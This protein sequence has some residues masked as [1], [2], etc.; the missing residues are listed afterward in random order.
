[1]GQFSPQLAAG[2][3]VALNVA[4]P[5]QQDILEKLKASKRTLQQALESV[6]LSLKLQDL[7]SQKEK[8]QSNN[9]NAKMDR[10]FEDR[11]KAMKAQLEELKSKLASVGQTD[12]FKA[13]TE[14][15]GNAVKIIEEVNK[16]LE[17]YHRTLTPGQKAEIDALA[18]QEKQTEVE[19]AYQT[20]LDSTTRSIQERIAAAQALTKA[21]G[22]GY[23]AVKAASVGAQLAST[24]GREFNDPAR[25]IDQARL[26]SQLEAE[27]EARHRQEITATLDKLGDQIELEK[28]LSAAQYQGAEAVRQAQ[29]AFKLDQIAKDNDAESAKKLIAAE[30][31]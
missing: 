7:T 20:K 9:E 13:I 18:I 27:Y 19:L 25:A 16:A 2:A 10:P 24:M 31:E 11:I 30:K 29:L 3:K 1:I 22:Q 28:A 15:H 23:E 4:L 14:G 21:I 5:N 26:K 8:L 12:A 6:P 17:R